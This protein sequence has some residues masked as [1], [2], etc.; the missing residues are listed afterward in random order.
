MKEG[1]KLKVWRGVGHI[2]KGTSNAREQFRRNEEA[3]QVENS[4][5]WSDRNFRIEVLRRV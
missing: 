4:T 2:R 3:G 5:W 1:R